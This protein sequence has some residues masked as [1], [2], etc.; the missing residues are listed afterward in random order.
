MDE[1]AEI[2]GIH[3]KVVLADGQRH[4]AKSQSRYACFAIP[5]TAQPRWLAAAMF[6]TVR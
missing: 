2:A 5:R 1:L 6:D 3:P 4:E